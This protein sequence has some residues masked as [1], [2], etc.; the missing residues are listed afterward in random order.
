MNASKENARKALKLVRWMEEGQEF[1]E[2]FLKAVE[3]KLPP[4]AAYRRAKKR[5]QQRR[6]VNRFLGVK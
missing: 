5:K 6:R 4:E 2:E 3:R 1:M